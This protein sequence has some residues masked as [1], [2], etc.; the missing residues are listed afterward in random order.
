VDPPLPRV[1]IDRVRPEVDCGRFPIKRVAGDRVAVEAIIFADG[2]DDVTARVLYRREQDTRWAS[3]PLV[4]AGNDHWY[5]SFPVSDVGRYRYTV[6]AW[7]DPFKTWRRELVARYRAGQDIAV[8]VLVG[9]ELAEAVADRTRDAETATRLRTWARVLRTESDPDR[10][11]STAEDTDI[12]AL[13]MAAPDPSTVL[14]FGRELAVVVDR[15]LARF[16]AWYELFPRSTAAEPGAHGT[17][18]TTSERLAEIAALG[19][20]IVYLPPIHPIGR[21]ARKGRNNAVEAAPGDEGSPWAIGSTEGGH[22]SVHPALGTLADF[23]ALVVEA[24]RVGLEV[25]LDIAFQCAPDHPWVSQH[26]AW[27]KHRPDGTIRYAENPPKKYQD[28]YP[29]D[30]DTHDWRALWQA[31]RDV[32]AFWVGHGVR[33]FRVD[34]PHTKAFPFWEWCIGDL[35]R[36]YPDL[37]F[38]SEAFTRPGPMYRLAKLGFTQSYTYFTWRNTRAELEAYFRE[39]TTDPVKQFFRPNVWPNTPDILHAFLQQ[40]G[41]PAFMVRA[42]LAAT[43]AANYGVYGP[44]FEWAEHEPREPGSE[45]YRDSE[46]YQIRFR[47]AASAGPL[48]PLLGALNAIRRQHA[49]LQSDESLVI[50]ATDNPQ[51]MCYSKSAGDHAIVVVIN[52]DPVYRQSGWTTLDLGALGVGDGPFA[53]HDL[54]SDQ[55]FRWQGPHNFVEL[56][57]GTSPAHVLRIERGARA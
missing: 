3:E 18:R 26:P 15:P 36:E 29:I 41:V 57:P 1:V 25:A 54:L 5:A 20:D 30:F 40:G 10:R 55:T 31:L 35:K 56:T 4:L 6:E 42:I 19:F 16:S 17:L 23:D 2:H 39:L 22:T 28:I 48:R 9:A 38:L 50:H 53:A 45:E 7:V 21:A 27:F 34:N 32:F 49:A 14:R 37:I 24:Q 46:K 12:A 44:A 51:I 8:E 47:D 43:L 11:F 33:V 13:A 52:L